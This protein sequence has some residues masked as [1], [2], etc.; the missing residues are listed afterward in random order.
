M[1]R[2]AI[3]QEHGN[4]YSVKFL[5][6]TRIYSKDKSI[7][8]C[9]FEGQ[10]EKYFS[11]RLDLKI[12]QDK[13]K[14]INTGG[15]KSVLELNDSIM[16]HPVYKESYFVC[17]IDH[18]FEDWFVNPNPN[19][20]Y[21]TNCYSIENLYSTE[22]CFKRVISSEFGINEFN[23]SRIDFHKCID[24]FNLR[25]TE[26]F[27]KVYMFNCWV[28]AH[29][30]ME[31][32]S[33]APKKL[34]VRNVKITSLVNI[35]LNSVSAIYDQSDPQSIFKDYEE[36]SLCEEALEEAKLSFE[37]KENCLVFRGKQQIEF[38]RIFL[39]RLKEDRTSKIPNFFSSKGSV[40]LG[41]SKDNCISELSQYADTPE[42]LISFLESVSR[43][44]AV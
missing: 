43:I 26:F 11:S 34:N 18:D 20:I 44:Y 12:G 40:I 25:L 22:S 38:M 29:R 35:Q 9:I 8:I 19:K 15:K 10:D 42:C 16:L 6:F 24:L 7:I 3:M 39:M 41:L 1:D 31:R 30:I 5:E 36:L 27:D 37:N 2:V 14:G 32:D 13:W 17:F 4:S 23:E 21:V 33:K 28:K